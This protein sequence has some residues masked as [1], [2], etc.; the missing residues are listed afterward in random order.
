MTGNSVSS[1]SS[2]S[3]FSLRLTTSHLYY[4]CVLRSVFSC[5][6]RS[7]VY[8]HPCR[9]VP[10][11]IYPLPCYEGTTSASLASYKMKNKLT[12]LIAS[13]EFTHIIRE[14]HDTMMSPEFYCHF[15][16]S[17]TYKF[18]NILLVL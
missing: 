7:I 8:C 2:I 13:H 15:V 5:C 18:Q 1:S 10:R 11:S 6:C 4:T 9:L 14:Y 3:R 17:D 16:Y 12:A